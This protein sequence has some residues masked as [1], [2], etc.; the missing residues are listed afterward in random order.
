MPE[1]IC[2]D[3]EADDDLPTVTALIIYQGDS[4]C[5]EHFEV[6]LARHKQAAIEFEKKMAEIQEEGRIW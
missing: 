2:V 1:L 3:H 5:E 6:R 4:L